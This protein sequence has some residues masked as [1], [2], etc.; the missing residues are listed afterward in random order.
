MIVCQVSRARL[1]AQRAAA[2]PDRAQKDSSGPDVAQILFLHIGQATNGLLSRFATDEVSTECIKHA[3]EFV[4]IFHIFHL[5]AA[6]SDAR[7]H[8]DQCEKSL[9]A[10]ALRLLSQCFHIFGHM[11][12]VVHKGIQRHGHA[13]I[14]VSCYPLL[15]RTNV[16]VRAPSQ[17]LYI[18]PSIPREPN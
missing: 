11:L 3:P 10:A 2:F 9:K 18:G 6:L 5:S 12:Y 15:L 8:A 7:W 1:L 13:S 14:T 16:S 4:H 17:C